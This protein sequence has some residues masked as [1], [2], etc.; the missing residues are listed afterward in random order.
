MS[1]KPG[2]LSI[3]GLNVDDILI[4]NDGAFIK[5]TPEIQQNKEQARL[6]DALRQI[7]QSQLTIPH[8]LIGT[9]NDEFDVS[10][11]QRLQAAKVIATDFR[12]LTG[13]DLENY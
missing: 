11:Q 9:P 5:L 7:V 2:I 13:I 4:T 12:K 3:K 8:N 6:Y 1:E 10:Y